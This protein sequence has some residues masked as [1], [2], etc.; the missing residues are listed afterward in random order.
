MHRF[1][2]V[3]VVVASNL[4]LVSQTVSADGPSTFV[5]TPAEVRLSGNFARAQLVVTR[6]DAGGQIGER[7]EDLTHGAAF[8]SSDTNVVAVDLRGQLL[9]KGNGAARREDGDRRR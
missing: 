1:W 7:S 6:A 4:S 9:A 3:A 2:L 8:Q 5:V